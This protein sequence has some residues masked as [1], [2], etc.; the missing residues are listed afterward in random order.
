MVQSWPVKLLIVEVVAEYEAED[1][2]QEAQLEEE[3]TRHR[4]QVLEAKD[5]IDVVQHFEKT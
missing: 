3:L 5:T 1:V 2:G 4:H